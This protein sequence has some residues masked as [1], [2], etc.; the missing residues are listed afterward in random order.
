MKKLRQKLWF[1]AFLVAST[2]LI[3]SY[4]LEVAFK[5]DEILTLGSFLWEFLKAAICGLLII[6]TFGDKSEKKRK[7]RR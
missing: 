5:G 2:F 6:V 1:R 7:R 4:A 3:V